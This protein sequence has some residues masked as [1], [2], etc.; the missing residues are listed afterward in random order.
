MW[1]DPIKDEDEFMD[2][3]MGLPIEE[4]EERILLIQE[5][6]MSEIIDKKVEEGK[7]VFSEVENGMLN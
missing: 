4:F 2:M 1:N 7:M 5:L 3:L 6:I